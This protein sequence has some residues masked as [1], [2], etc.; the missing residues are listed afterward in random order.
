LSIRL[1]TSDTHR[2]T[3]WDTTI[4]VPSDWYALPPAQRAISLTHE[5]VHLAQFARLGTWRFGLQ[6][7]TPWGR[8]ALEREAFAA[9][10][11][12]VLEAYGQNALLARR[13]YYIEQF[14]GKA[15]YWCDPWPGSAAAWVDGQ[16]AAFVPGT[17]TP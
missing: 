7:A 11:G 14:T 15:Y 1:K 2:C 13:A 5:A 16:F 10:F 9:E 17:P 4:Y 3:T 12:T 8:T 6:Y